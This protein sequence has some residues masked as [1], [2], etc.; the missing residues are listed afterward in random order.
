MSDGVIARSIHGEVAQALD[1]SGDERIGWSMLYLHIASEGRV[2]VGAKLKSGDRIGHPSCE[3][4]LAMA[5][6]VHIARK[7][8][9]EWL[10]ADGAIPF[11]LGGWIA[12]EEP[13]EYDGALVK[14]HER[15]ESCECKN[16]GVNGITW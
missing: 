6:H 2:K 13:Y 12:Q 5:A 15:R 8:N 14:G 10:N 1:P 11:N 16:P 3:G 9:G 7:F 4:G